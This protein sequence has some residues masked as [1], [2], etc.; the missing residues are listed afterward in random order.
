M[1]S[2]GSVPVHSTLLV[3]IEQLNNLHAG[4]PEGIPRPLSRIRIGFQHLSENSHNRIRM[5]NKGRDINF[6]IPTYVG[7]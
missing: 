4:R 6:L 7:I 1:G 2:A 5:R 3:L